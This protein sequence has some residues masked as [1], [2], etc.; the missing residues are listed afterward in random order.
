MTDTFAPFRAERLPKFGEDVS[1]CCM[2]EQHEECAD[3]DCI[4]G[5]HPDRLSDTGP[6]PES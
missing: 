1:E 6:E 5:C 2:F 3:D 4:C